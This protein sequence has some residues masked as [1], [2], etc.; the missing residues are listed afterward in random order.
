MCRRTRRERCECGRMTYVNELLQNYLKILKI[1]IRH[2][3]NTCGVLNGCHTEYPSNRLVQALETAS[4]HLNG[5]HY[6]QYTNI[7]SP[8]VKVSDRNTRLT[9]PTLLKSALTP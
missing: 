6:N 5:M 1:Q 8:L 3:S 7:R 9:V 2:A 4:A